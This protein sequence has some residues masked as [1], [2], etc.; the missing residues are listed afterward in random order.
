MSRISLLPSLALW[1]STARK[2]WARSWLP[3][4]LLLVLAV[5]PGCRKR[6]ASSKDAPGRASLVASPKDAARSWLPPNRGGSRFTV[7]AARVYTKQTLVE[8]VNGG[9]DA[10]IDAGLETLLHVRITDPAGKFTAVEVQVSDYGTAAKA[11]AMLAKERPPKARKVQLGDRGFAGRGEVMFVK[12]RHLVS[13]AVQPAG[14]TPYAPVAEIA[15]RVA[16]TPG[17]R[18]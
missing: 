6:A 1:M 5:P 18:W 2:P 12:G 7:D 17:A 8:L 4:A 10:L 16:S 11:R 9:A 3:G 14:K 13:V 15:R